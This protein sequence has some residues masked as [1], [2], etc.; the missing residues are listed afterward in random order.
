MA[1]F[2][3]LSRAMAAPQLVPFPPGTAAKASFATDKDRGADKLLDDD[4]ATLLAGAAGSCKGATEP[5]WVDIRF[6]A[7]VEN[8]AGIETGTS[9]PFANYYP[10]AMEFWVDTDGN[11]T[12]DTLAG[13]ATLGPG[14]A[15]AGTHL[16]TGRIPRAHG[17]R[18]LV[19][20]EN[21]AGVH[22]AFFLS[23]IRLLADGT[24]APVTATPKDDSAAALK[25]GSE[26][27]TTA[28]R[29]AAPKPDQSIV[30]GGDT[31]PG[32][33]LPLPA[34]TKVEASVRTDASGDPANLFDGDP[35]T[36][37]ASAGGVV[38]DEGTPVSIVL[39]F[40][41]PVKNLAG[42]E[43][44]ESDAY[45]N[46]Y[47]LELEFWADSDGDGR[48]DTLLGRTTRV[49]PAKQ[50]VGRHMFDGRLE[51]A[52]AL[53]I[54]AVRQH[55]GGAKRAFTMNEMRLVTSA[56]LPIIPATP[57]SYLVT[58]YVEALPM[59]TTATVSFP[60]EPGQGAEALLDHDPNTSLNG[61]QGTAREGQ[62]S[63]IFL[64]FPQPVSDLDGVVLGRSDPYGNYVWEEM[65]FY[66]DTTGNGTYDSFVG[67][68]TGGGA[69]RKRFSK[70]VPR[71]YGLEL[72][73]T[74]QRVTGTRRCFMLNGID[75]L[76]F[77]DAPGE[78][79]MRCVLEDFGDLS[80]WRT[81][82]DNTAQPEG[83]RY[84]G[85]YTYI[86]GVR[87]PDA[88]NGEPVG[89]IRYC[90]KDPK[91]PG[92]ASN[93]L[94][95]KRGAVSAREAFMDRMTFRANPQGYPCTINFALVDSR[96]KSA[97]T[98]DVALDG[99]DWKEYAIDLT[100]K[101]WPE[102]TKLTPPYHI[103]NLWL[104]S[105][106]GGTGDVLIAAIT[107]VGTV[108]RDLRVTI[109]PVWESLACDPGHPVAVTYRL[110]NALDA[111][112]QAPLVV[113]LY[114]SFDPKHASPLLTQTI[115]V[116]LP[117]WGERV[118]VVDF[119]AL[120]YGHYEA[121]LSL[122]ASG[123]AAECV[124]EVAVARLNGS[125][126]NRKPMWIGSQHPDGWISDA[127]NQFVYRE[128]VKPLGMDCYRGG[129][130]KEFVELGLLF[131]AGLPGMPKALR[132]PK[133][134]NDDR[135]EPTDYASYEAWCKAEAARTLA[136]YRDSILCLEY[137]NEPDLPDFCYRPE[138]DAYL[139]MWRAWAAGV[140]AGAPGI[141]LGTGGNTVSHGK[142]K[143][144]F[145]P[146]MY[147]ELAKE[148]DVAVW[149]AHGPLG[150]YTTRHRMVE[151]WLEQGG[152]PKAQQRLGNSEAG[153]VSHDSSVERLTQADCLVKKIGWA[154]A[155]ADSLFYLW[156]TTT[157]TYDP[158]GGYLGGENWGLITSS[159]RLKPSGL[160]MNELIRQLANTDGLGEVRLDGRLQ[161]C[162][163][164]HEDGTQIWLSWPNEA[165]AAFLLTLAASG[166]VEFSD[167]F[168]R[169]ETVA[170]KAGRLTLRPNGWP[171][172]LR[173]A[174]GV[175]VGQAATP[176]WLHVPALVGVRPGGQAAFHA[177][178][179]NAWNRDATLAA[180]VE[181]VA[182]HIVAKTDVAV[183]KG[184][185]AGAD[186][187]FDLPSGARAGSLGY[188]L[189]LAGAGVGVDEVL[190]LTIAVGELVPRAGHPLVAGGKPV[191]PAKSARIVLDQVTDVHDLVDDPSTPK[192]A[193]KED[194]SVVASLAH[195]DKGLWLSFAVQD[196]T[197]V[198]GEPGAKLWAKDSVQVAFAMEGKQT[199]FGLTEAGGGAGFCW[200][201][202]DGKLANQPLPW[203]LAATRAGGTTT[204]TCYVPFADLGGEYRPGTMLRMT[205]MINEDD[206]KG[207][208][209]L[210]KWFDGIHPGKDV[211]KFGYLILE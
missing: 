160:A 42:V 172:Y 43:T 51:Q 69:G 197:H 125:R 149:H 169:R 63:S 92:K 47:P 38:P 142:E 139:K 187:A 8:L 45:H 32:T 184:G 127:E 206:G 68:A 165:G 28:R 208:V 19:T 37:F 61:K 107:A 11:G 97:H 62:P 100:A 186:F 59:G 191:P 199:E 29:A 12:F 16:F 36:W 14:K 128:V 117:K 133:E 178:F 174:R 103:E 210:M 181:D 138:I 52:Y 82:A 134:Q 180:T 74:R 168:G 75:G 175:K 72:R 22:R 98:P 41:S 189:K 202:P 194:L 89:Q 78:G 48:C 30:P 161:T 15:C 188:V 56:A 159:Q 153:A 66:A 147:T 204:Y 106:R 99:K 58:S 50:C 201:S 131:T 123:V 182:G 77:K 2:C 119:G 156:F 1:L 33:I 6:G 143:K 64:R 132:K 55:V 198:P 137:Y 81:W 4:P 7:P 170:P 190:A 193:G 196:Q 176:D 207:R 148:A 162:A 203:P 109:A 171:F 88:P 164:R 124:D 40:P 104:H 83:E 13:K 200:L 95:A 86:C 67:T 73:V 205:F 126:V 5:V 84:Y 94:R 130:K 146:R 46:Y 140:R 57:R 195:D 35:G 158:Q 54:R 101:A 31:L 166:P 110:R 105:A 122:R 118:Q 154:K 93:W 173:A 163:Y 34:G 17:L 79:E 155:Q 26:A 151:N 3:L 18:L 39:H 24:A 177:T 96:G 141:L 9:D 211:A 115:P 192:W 44:G 157:D 113:N 102:S 135:G 21:D 112:L 145:N 91:E 183:P 53:E 70:P 10:K 209:R 120:P 114:S 129:P 144:D 20:E 185:E 111:E 136:P 152:K 80:S 65:S 167:M 121:V 108:G 49:G 71:V 23:G 25:R 85:G 116:V 76:V 90:F 179:R 150:N 27:A 60:T 87:R